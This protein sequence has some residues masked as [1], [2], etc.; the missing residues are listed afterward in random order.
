MTGADTMTDTV[1]L[2][3]V[4]SVARL[5]LSRPPVNALNAHLISQLDE[6]VS[7][8]ETAPGVHVLILT[9]AGRCFAAGADL[10]EI[11]GLPVGEMSLWNRRLERAVDRVARLPIPVIAAVNGHALGGGFELVLAADFRFLSNAA[12]VGLPEVTLGIVP[13][14]GGMSRLTR[15]VGAMRAKELLMSGRSIRPDEADAL[16][17]AWQ[18]GPQGA[19][20]AAEDLAEVLATAPQPAIRAVKESV[21]RSTDSALQASLAADRATLTTVF[22]TDEARAG[23]D[24]FLKR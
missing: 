11:A 20:A 16:G 2:E 12:T 15:T 9:G 17:L 10:D 23:I 18:A 8:V 4:D 24:A 21:D 7:V 3:I 1:T 22:A 6:A 14:A 19:L 13:G 5:T